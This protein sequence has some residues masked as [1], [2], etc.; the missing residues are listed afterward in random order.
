[1]WNALHAGRPRVQ[2]APK[3]TSTNHAKWTD[4]IR[5]ASRST[6]RPTSF[7]RIVA[8]LFVRWWI[9]VFTPSDPLALLML[10]VAVSTPCAKKRKDGEL[11]A[12][13]WAVLVLRAGPRNREIDAAAQDF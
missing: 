1:M 4:K 12:S 8:V 5:T 2:R 10:A 13:C 6:A 11:G 7:H 9:L 3:I